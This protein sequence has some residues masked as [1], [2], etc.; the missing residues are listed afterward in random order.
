MKDRFTESRLASSTALATSILMA[1]LGPVSAQDSS[2]SSDL[3]PD[4]YR[5]GVLVED[6]IVVCYSDDYPELIYPEGEDSNNSEPILIFVDD[7]T[8][9]VRSDG[10]QME[11]FENVDAELINWGG[12]KIEP[13]YLG[14]DEPP[15]FVGEDLGD[16][17]TVIYLNE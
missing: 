5:T 1:S 11:F 16:Q 7:A 3:I 10:L 13:L 12:Y 8:K 9:C 14:L 2:P 4:A 17:G 15:M 6:G